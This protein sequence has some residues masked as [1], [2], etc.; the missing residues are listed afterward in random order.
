MEHFTDSPTAD[1][2]IPT[3]LSELDVQDL[4]CYI[5]DIE[6]ELKQRDEALADRSEEIERLVAERSGKNTRVEVVDWRDESYDSEH[7]NAHTNMP[8]NRESLDTRK[9]CSADI[10]LIS[11]GSV[12]VETP[13]SATSGGGSQVTEFSAVE[14]NEPQMPNH[15]RDG[16]SNDYY[17]CFARTALGGVI[18]KLQDAESE[19]ARLREG[20]AMA[21]ECDQLEREVHWSE[22][23][24]DGESRT[25]HSPCG[26][27]R[28]SLR[29]ITNTKFND[30][31]AKVQSRYHEAAPP[32]PGVPTSSKMVQL[33]RRCCLPSLNQLPVKRVSW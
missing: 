22:K 4:I 8:N 32:P 2:N 29:D 28:S 6:L 24:C 26:A 3:H 16:Q 17:D 13:R 12:D 15:G 25:K 1:P 11:E 27:G 23:D 33:L 30:A 9:K 20:G 10:T 18:T 31:G 7:S 19:I 5:E 14:Y 21:I